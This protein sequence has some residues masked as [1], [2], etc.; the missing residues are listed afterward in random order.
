M[1]DEVPQGERAELQRTARETGERMGGMDAVIAEHGS[2]LDKINGSIATLAEKMSEQATTLAVMASSVGAIER[3]LDTKMLSHESRLT[4]IEAW[5]AEHRGSGAMARLSKDRSLQ[6]YLA[7]FAAA[8][9]LFGII[10]AALVS[11]ATVV[12][13]LA[14]NGKL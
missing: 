6:W 10:I 5:V 3:V 8:I 1:P 9:A 11:I 7:W 14:A 2:R 12:V 4:V 13:T